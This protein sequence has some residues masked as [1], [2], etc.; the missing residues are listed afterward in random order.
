[1]ITDEM[2]KNWME[3]H[4]PD[5]AQAAQYGA[6]R[7]GALEFARIIVANSPQ[8]ADQTASLRK[9]REAMW[10]ANASIACGGK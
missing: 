4:V 9:V 10:A 7:K 3:H 1:M 6:I 5:G 8:S 2:L